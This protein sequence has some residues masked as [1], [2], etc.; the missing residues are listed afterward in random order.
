[1][2]IKLEPAHVIV[3]PLFTIIFT[4]VAL[5]TTFPVL[6]DLFHILLEGAPKD[7]SLSDILSHL[8]SIPG[9]KSVHSLHIWSLT[10]GRHVL[11]AHIV[12][13]DGGDGNCIMKHARR[14]LCEK[15]CLTE[16]TV[17]IENYQTIMEDCESCKYYDS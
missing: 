5:V 11:S 1:M 17:Q 3:D 16:L 13:E 10:A 7:I 2:I 14:V 15:Y 8:Q 9:V 6:C 12:K 4:I